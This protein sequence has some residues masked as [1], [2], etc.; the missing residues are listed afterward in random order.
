MFVLHEEHLLSA[1]NV[2]SCN[3]YM[4]YQYHNHC[5]F[6]IADVK[7]FFGHTCDARDI[8]DICYI[9]LINASS[10]SYHAPSLSTMAFQLTA[11]SVELLQN[12][13]PEDVDVF[14]TQHV[15]QFLSIKQVGQHPMGSAPDRY[16]I[17]LSDGIHYMQAMLA[18]QLNGMVQE[19]IIG[20]NTVAVLEKL[21]C[22]YVQA[23]RFH[24]KWLCFAQVVTDAPV[25]LL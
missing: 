3:A 11:G 5:I 12:A 23:K 21:T 19:N 24:P 13:T 2:I 4:T 9:L 18:T 22:N 16:R 10:H 1:W 8:V 14:N 15:M 7:G 17:I 6:R 25:D 20:K